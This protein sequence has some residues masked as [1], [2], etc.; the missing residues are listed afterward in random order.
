MFSLPFFLVGLLL[1][2]NDCLN[3]LNSSIFVTAV[4]SCVLFILFTLVGLYNYGSGINAFRCDF[5]KNIFLFYLVSF[6]LSIILFI[7]C[8]TFSSKDYHFIRTISNGTLFILCTHL[9]IIW[10]IN[11]ILENSILISI[12]VLLISYP[13]IMLCERYCPILIGK[14][15]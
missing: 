11:S 12:I 14:R 3:R 9:I 2:E 13:L 10:K 6:A 15:S 4:V 7:I 5:G 1:K 8:H